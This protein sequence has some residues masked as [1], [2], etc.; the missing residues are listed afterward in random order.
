MNIRVLVQEGVN[1]WAEAVDES[2]GGTFVKKQQQKNTFMSKLEIW[3]LIL[4]I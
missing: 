2:G 1:A 4:K 3:D